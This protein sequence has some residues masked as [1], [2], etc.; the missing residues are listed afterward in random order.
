MII[1]S[2]FFYWWCLY[3]LGGDLL[4]IK[5]KVSIIGQVKFAL[6]D[7]LKIGYSKHQDKKL[8]IIN[9]YIYS[10]STYKAYLKHCCYFVK[11]CKLNH[12]CKTLDDCKPYIN[13]YLKTRFHLSPYTIKLEAC[14]IAKLYGCSSYDFIPTP[15]RHRANIT[16]SRGFAKRD[17]IFSE[18]KNKELVT[19]CRSTG[20]RRREVTH[21]RGNQ[22]I[23]KDGNYY[24]GVKGKGGRYRE[25][26]IIGDVNLV[27]NM[28]KSAG[29]NKVFKSVSTNADIHSYRAD[30]CNSL[31]NMFARDVKTLPKSEVYCCRNDLAGVWYDKKAMLIAS[32]NLGHNRISVIAEHYL[33]A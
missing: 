12:K 23:F 24:L 4:S 21:I 1:F 26:L 16:R 3:C 9:D 28:M 6:D 20:L 17:K 30:Y 32:S 7:K 22:L 27:V 10:W 25:S 2:Y 19:F 8:G 31:Y 33:R 15:K 14:A 18:E 13:E 29:D 11:W 5:N